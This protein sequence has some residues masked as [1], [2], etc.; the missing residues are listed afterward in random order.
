MHFSFF[1]K[2]LLF[3]QNYAI[4]SY[5]VV[6]TY[7]AIQ[8]KNIIG[9]KNKMPVLSAGSKWHD[10]FFALCIYIEGKR[11]TNLSI[12]HRRA[13]CILLSA[14]HVEIRKTHLRN[15]ILKSILS[16]YM[17][18]CPA[19]VTSISYW[20]WN[21]VFVAFGPHKRM[22][23]ILTSKDSIFDFL[24]WQI[25]QRELIHGVLLWQPA[26]IAEGKAETTFP[27]KM[28]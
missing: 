14:W 18:T 10:I 7:W 27:S 4:H 24:K 15:E 21:C 22:G 2:V 8:R 17:M 1:F 3:E 28:G 13:W 20:W 26:H 16:G 23:H 11:K 25:F 12:N 9:G 19:P 5:W 6:Q